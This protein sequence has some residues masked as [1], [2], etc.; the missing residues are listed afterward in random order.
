[1]VV[2]APV[3]PT[4]KMAEHPEISYHGFFKMGADKIAILKLSERL[5]LT[6]I[7]QL[8]L[9]TPFVLQAVLPDR[10]ILIDTQEGNRKLEIT[11]NENTDTSSQASAQPLA[12]R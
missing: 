2:E 3:E 11:F 1:M 9:E 4:V 12:G 7:G 6:R 10:V 8:L 5:V